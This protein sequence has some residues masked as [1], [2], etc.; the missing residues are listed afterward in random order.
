MSNSQKE[1]AA[2]ALQHLEQAWSYYTPSETTPPRA[3][4]GEGEE[5]YYEYVKAAA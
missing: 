1:I 5:G 3:Q 4:A 2:K